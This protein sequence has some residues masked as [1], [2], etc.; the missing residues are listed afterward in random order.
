MSHD[1][2]GQANPA[3]LR[4]LVVHK[5]AQTGHVAP[6]RDEQQHTDR[7]FEQQ[8][9]VADQ[10]FALA[11]ADT[12]CQTDHKDKLPRERVKKPAAATGVVRDGKPRGTRIKPKRPRDS[13]RRTRRI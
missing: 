5:T 9:R 2:S 10:P 1:I 8:R 4:H 13:Q 11:V 6:R 12:D 3:K 7:Q